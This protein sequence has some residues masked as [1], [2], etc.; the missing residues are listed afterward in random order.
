MANDINLLYKKAYKEYLSKDK[1]IELFDIK[2]L[3]FKEFS[4][5][6]ISKCVEVLHSLSFNK[7]RYKNVDIL[8]EFYEMVIR[9]AFKQTKGLFLTHPNIVYFVCTR[10]G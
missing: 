10:S 9:D 8:G 2:G 6:L 4:P 1:A 7:N 3:D 5:Y